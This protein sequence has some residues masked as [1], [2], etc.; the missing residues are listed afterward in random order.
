MPADLTDDDK[1]ILAATPAPPP[2]QDFT[3]VSRSAYARRGLLLPE[4]GGAPVGK[5]ALG[6][7]NGS[8]STD[9]GR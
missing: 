6:F 5:P 2:R 9:A 3:I 4:V 1:A 7:R 8:V